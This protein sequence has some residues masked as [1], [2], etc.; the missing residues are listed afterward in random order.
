[1]FYAAGGGGGG[2]GGA[3]IKIVHPDGGIEHNVLAGCGKSTSLC[4]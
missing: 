1:M 3:P 2:G 4:T